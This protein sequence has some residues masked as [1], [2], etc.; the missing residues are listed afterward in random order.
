MPVP[1]EYIE[2]DKEALKAFFQSL[3]IAGTA[4][5]VPENPTPT[6]AEDMALRVMIK[7]GYQP[8]KGLGPHLNSI[9]GPI[10]IQENSDK[11]VEDEGT[12]AEALVEME[13]W[14]EQERPKFQSQVEDLEGINLGDETEMREVQV[15]KQMPPDLR[16]KLVELLKEYSDVFAWS[17]Q[18][19]LGLDRELWNTNYPCSQLQRMRP[20]IALKIKEE[21]EKQWNVRFLA[22]ANYPQ[23]VANIVPLPKKDKKV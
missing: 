12:E 1:E 17:Y 6:V 11:P 19:M 21:V 3:K 23:W 5:S 22:V 8:S 20:E 18:D 13:R 4:S 16:S 9:L 14:V 15:G 2:G 10:T 7:E